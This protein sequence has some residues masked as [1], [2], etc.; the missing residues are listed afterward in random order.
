MNVLKK[1]PKSEMPRERLLRDGIE[2]LSLH[3]LLAILLG[4]GTQGKSV[5]ALAQELVIH[6][7]GIEGLVHASIE[8]LTQVKGMGQA[9]AMLLKATFGISLRL[10]KEKSTPNK[11]ISTTLDALE[12][13]K[14]QIGHLQKEALLVILRDIKS[15]LICHEVVSL[16]I[17]S[18]VLVH[19][20]EVFQPAIR[21]GAYSI[22]ICHNHPSGDPT[23]SQADIDL[24]RQL[25]KSSRVIGIKLVDHL[26]IGRDSYISMRRENYL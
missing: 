15:R 21:H 14:H 24:T 11:K 2:A 7:G 8:E 3:E 17:L 23:P 1:W 6:F 10:A 18:E 19:P 22:I 16:G 4:T 20:R 12:I 25:K 5:L 13:A 9:K 26:I